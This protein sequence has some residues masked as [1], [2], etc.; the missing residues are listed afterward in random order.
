MNFKQMMVIN[1]SGDIKSAKNSDLIAYLSAQIKN[2]RELGWDDKDIII[3]SNVK[4]DIELPVVLL[5]KVNNTCL[6]GSKTFAILQAYQ[7]GIVSGPVWLH[8]LDAWQNV[9]FDLPDFKDVGIAEYSTPK[10]NGGSVFYRPSAVD[11]IKLVVDDIDKN[12]ADKEEPFL[13][14]VFRAEQNKHRVTRLE[15]GFNV[16]CSGFVKRYASAEKPVKVCHFH[17]K[18]RMAWMTQVM[19]QHKVGK[20]ASD[21]LINLLRVNKLAPVILGDKQYN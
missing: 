9:A 12:T 19:D 21:R 1:L 17:P 4:L 3:M 20:C 16:G 5:D 8:D 15:H 11:L 10:Y 7:S 18:N 2:S 6:T 14:K 13:N